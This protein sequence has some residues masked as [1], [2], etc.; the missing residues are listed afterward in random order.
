MASQR[1]TSTRPADKEEALPPR[2]NPFL[3]GHEEA[4]RILADSLRSRRLHHAW[5]ITGP[6]GI[7]KA[8]LAYRF[9]RHLL[10]GT[11]ETTENPTELTGSGALAFDPARPLFHRV[12]AGG[13]ADLYTIERQYDGK[14]NRMRDEIVVADVR[15]VGR[16]MHLTAAEGGWRV[17]VVDSADEMNRNAANAILKLLE[18]PP[19]RV[20]LVLLAHA[21]G[22]LPATIRSRCR[23]LPL[24]PLSDA[25]VANLL[26]RY[27][28]KLAEE[29]A[30]A[31]AR[32]AEGSIGLALDLA[33]QGGLGLY[34][35][36]L[37][38]LQTLPSLD[39]P[40]LHGFS[41]RISRRG[42]DTA[43]RTAS[44]LLLWWLGRLVRGG[45]SG[46]SPDEVVEGEGELMRRLVA[47]GG[48]DRWLE[49]WENVGALLVR[50]DE[51]N[52]DR[53]QVVLSAFFAVKNAAGG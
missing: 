5:L 17:V 12:A 35:E 36:I 49:V 20:L 25:T 7:G 39:A 4:E 11:V 28:A 29:D 19:E 32:L 21:T 48:L 42:A 52:L 37:S 30:A 38:L 33:E 27:G 2:A 34:R 1:Q 8:T 44:A 47:A 9:A 18:E 43:Y 15:G 31:L 10:A 41:E 16:F 40:A 53:R 22:R 50:A 26:R 3:I 45:V 51:V 23:T 14:R 46:C 6:K 13:H 24:S